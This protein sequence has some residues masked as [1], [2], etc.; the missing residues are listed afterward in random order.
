MPTT[1]EVVSEAEDEDWLAL[2][3]G[4][5]AAARLALGRETWDQVCADCH[6]LSGEG[7]IGPPIAQNGALVNAETLTQLVQEG[8]DRPDNESYM[9]PVGRGWTRA[10]VVALIAY[11]RSNEVLAPA[12]QPE[13]TETETQEA[14][15]R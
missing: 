4:D 8:Q 2:T 7:D 14:D 10:Q 9:P 11:I 6:G 12:E 1:V 15:P 13:P 3:G 5:G